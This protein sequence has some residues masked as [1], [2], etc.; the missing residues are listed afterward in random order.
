MIEEQ[1]NIEM[2]PLIQNTLNRESELFQKEKVSLVQL[3]FGG[4]FCV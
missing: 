4:W 1:K 2:L 3:L